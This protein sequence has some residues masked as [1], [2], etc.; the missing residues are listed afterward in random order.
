MLST[1]YI[2]IPANDC[3]GRGPVQVLLCMGAY[4]AAKMALLEICGVLQILFY[5]LIISVLALDI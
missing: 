1:I 5:Y 2:F 3:V 4:D